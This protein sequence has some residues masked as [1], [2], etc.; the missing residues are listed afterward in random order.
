MSTTKPSAEYRRDYNR[1]WRYSSTSLDPTLD[2]GDA[3]G[4]PD[5]WYDG[6]LDAAAGREKWH[7]FSCRLAGG[8][9]EHKWAS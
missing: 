6:Y 1:G 5:A 3:R 7:T 8:C 4:E 9:D 2:H